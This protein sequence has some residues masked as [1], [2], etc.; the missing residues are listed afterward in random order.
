MAKPSVGHEEAPGGESEAVRRDGTGIRWRRVLVAMAAGLVVVIVATEVY[1][2]WR[3]HRDGL[4][5]TITPDGKTRAA[6]GP[7]P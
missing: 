7:C 6:L 3:L 1:Y 4:C 5:V 2:R